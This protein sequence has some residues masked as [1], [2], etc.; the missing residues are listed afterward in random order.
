MQEWNLQG[1][2]ETPIDKVLDRMCC[3]VGEKVGIIKHL[4][5]VKL[6]SND[7]SVFQV[8]ASK[9]N[10]ARF[11]PQAPMSDGQGKAFSKKRAIVSAIGEILERYCCAM[12]NRKE[13]FL[14]PYDQVKDQAI[15]LQDFALFADEQYSRWNSVLSR[16]SL[17]TQLYWV[18][19]Y[20]LTKKRAVLVPACFVFLPYTFAQV[21]DV[22]LLDITSTGA[23]AGATL[24]EAILSGIYEIVERDAAMIMWLNKLPLPR[25][26]PSTCKNLFVQRFLKKA[27]D[28]DLEIVVSNAT[29]D[30]CIPTMICVCLE[31]RD[32]EPFI[33][34]SAASDLNPERALLKALGEL[35]QCRAAWDWRTEC[36]MHDGYV[37]GGD[38]GQIKS[39]TDHLVLYAKTDLRSE[40]RFLTAGPTTIGLDQ[41]ANRW[42]DNVLN[43]VTLCVDH[44]KKRGLDVIV[45]DITPLDVK[46]AGFSVVK[47]IVPGTQPLT[48]AYHHRHLGGKRLYRVPK[49]LG[50]TDQE[51]SLEELNEWPH[52]FP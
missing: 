24:E 48:A 36:H 43:N 28:L 20:S 9:G 1:R 37:F 18:T 2:S 17:D 22:I 39:F 27:A 34:A 13:W 11:M 5:E 3:L 14:A 38:F 47:V 30:V 23:A 6:N 8:C 15:A 44:L 26:D 31:K 7:F 29:T 12:Y 40:F 16:V 49:A 10:I 19:G 35:I 52:P 32:K 45:V 33:T 4:A 50:Y 51:T 41:I 42:S 25:V 46:E 21:E